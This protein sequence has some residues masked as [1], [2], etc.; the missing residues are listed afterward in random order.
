MRSFIK[1][2]RRNGSS[3]TS[4]SDRSSFEIT[5]AAPP[6]V[7]SPP[8]APQPP[9]SV[10]P[11]LPQVSRS[12]PI[13]SP[14]IPYT[15]GEQ[16]TPPSMPSP[17]P[18]SSLSSPKKLLS[19]IK[20]LFSSGKQPTTPSS[21]DPLQKIAIPPKRNS[22]LKIIKS[23]TTTLPPLP[24]TTN[25]KFKKVP[26]SP[27]LSTTQPRPQFQS[28]MSQTH[29]PRVHVWPNPDPTVVPPKRVT[30]IQQLGAPISLSSSTNTTPNNN[31]NESYISHISENN[32]LRSE[33]NFQTKQVSFDN[34]SPASTNQKEQQIVSDGESEYDEESDSDQFSFVNDMKGG[35]NTSVKYYKNS[36]GSDRRKRKNE[37]GL[38]IQGGK[39]EFSERDLGY[40]VD[41]YS[42]Y[43]FEN[44]GL[45]DEDGVE[46][47]DDDDEVRYNKLFDDDDDQDVVGNGLNIRIERSNDD[48]EQDLGDG[49]DNDEE[50]LYNNDYDESSYNDI[51]SESTNIYSIDQPAPEISPYNP[52]PSTTPHHE[53]F[54]L[55]YHQSIQ[56]NRTNPTSSPPTPSSPVRPPSTTGDILEKYLDLTDTHTPKT[57]TFSSQSTH[58]SPLMELYDLHSP[59]INGLTIGTNLLHRGRKTEERSRVFIHRHPLDLNSAIYD[60][61]MDAKLGGE[62]GMRNRR[63]FHGSFEE[64]DLIV[65]GKVKEF[66][67]FSDMLLSKGKKDAVEHDREVEETV[68]GLGIENN[69]EIYSADDASEMIEGGSFE[70]GSTGSVARLAGES[71]EEQSVMEKDVKSVGEVSKQIPTRYEGGTE[72]ENIKRKSVQDLMTT[73]GKFNLSNVDGAPIQTDTRRESVVDMMETL[74]SLTLQTE[75]KG[76]IDPKHAEIAK[77]QRKSIADMMATLSNLALPNE[78]AAEPAAA[79]QQRQ[80]VANMMAT[81]SN[82]EENNKSSANKKSNR[83]SINDMMSTLA[84]LEQH[85]VVIP[86]SRSKRKS[87][88][89]MMATLDQIQIPQFTQPVPTTTTLG[90][91]PPT[92]TISDE[93]ADNTPILK[94]TGFFDNEKSLILDPDLLDEINQLPLD[95]DFDANQQQQSTHSHT[96]TPDFHRSNSYHNRPK[97][98]APQGPGAAPQTNRIEMLGGKTVTFYPKSNSV[99][100]DTSLSSSCSSGGNEEIFTEKP[101]EEEE[102]EQSSNENDYSMSGHRL[103]RE[104][105]EKNKRLFG[106]NRYGRGATPSPVNSLRGGRDLGTINER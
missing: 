53:V 60:K 52:T 6:P 105:I 86:K 29:V 99:S 13:N 68:F 38:G 93:P 81:L 55:A 102:D 74:S 31:S 40:E 23:K 95:Y 45:D 1:S 28:T 63:C 61:T 18:S 32:S 79:K 88:N 49:N 10:P 39:N 66:D 34:L 92:E 11:S 97:K 82:I 57:P 98:I 7:Q 90:P 9:Q 77:E 22:K 65:E 16:F 30:S 33:A 76:T 50:G 78:E 12:T 15:T 51:F 75:N 87:V 71:K 56:G 59:L 94:E 70:N 84:N 104:E 103:R 44:N 46:F 14:R 47:G 91:A 67:L 101:D 19:P 24:T 64:I 42:D 41:E 5:F 62:Y 21:N 35:R 58:A 3:A 20:N 17:A 83:K 69:G 26:S 100:R 80:S 72:S 8:Q 4:Q 2:H 73:L 96:P 106:I 43:D 54:N 89:E 48:L 27:A 85:T 25:T 37:V 36:D